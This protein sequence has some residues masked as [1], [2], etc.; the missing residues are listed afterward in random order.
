[1]VRRLPDRQRAAIVLRYCE[2]LGDADIAE[3]LGVRQP[4]VR[5]LVRRGLAQLRT[6]VER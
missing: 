2:G 6:Q 1:M 5:T 3:A 4:T